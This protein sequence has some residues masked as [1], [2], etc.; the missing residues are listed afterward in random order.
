M[1]KYLIIPLLLILAA[2][3]NF[4]MAS[5]P[6]TPV[7]PTI[8][9]N[10]AAWNFQY[11]PNMPATP[12]PSTTGKWQFTFPAVDGVHYLVTG[13]NKLSGTTLTFAAEVNVSNPNVVFDYH[14]AADN[15]C[16]SPA[17]VTPYMQRKGDQLLDSQPSYRSW[18]P[19][20]NITPGTLSASVPIDYHSWGN[21]NGMQ[22]QYGFNLLLG[23]L[24]A[25]GMTFG[26][27]CFAGHG[28]FIT[29]GVARFILKEFQVK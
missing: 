14:T 13:V 10:P 2:C 29:G 20:I 25:I 15:T 3:D 11:S 22:D 4:T 28:L 17:S 19:R 18:G 21:V 8:S 24:Q 12:S 6:P 1:L 27:G 5:T 16:P 9:L 26:G 7:T 23:D